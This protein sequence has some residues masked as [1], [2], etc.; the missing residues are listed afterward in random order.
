MRDT[1]KS[2][3]FDNASNSVSNSKN[4]NGMEAYSM[5]GNQQTMTIATNCS[6]YAPIHNIFDITSFYGSAISC[7]MCNNFQNNVCQVGLYDKVLSSLYER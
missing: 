5:A 4:I 1:K 7:N 6:G 3:E 2:I